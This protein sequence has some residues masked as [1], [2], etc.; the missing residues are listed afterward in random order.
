MVL[1]FDRPVRHRHRH[2]DL[3]GA[4]HATDRSRDGLS[5]TAINREKKGRPATLEAEVETLL[6]LIVA[7]SAQMVFHGMNEDDVRAILRYPH[8]MVGADGGVQDGQGLPHPR[9]YGTNARILGKYVREERL[10]T[11]EE[12]V[13]RM[14]SLAAQRF[15]LK[16]RGL[17]RAGYAADIVVFDPQRVIDTA[18]YS[19]P[20][21]FPVGIGHV[22]VNGRLVVDAG[23]HTGVRS[24]V[25]LQ[26]PGAT[27]GR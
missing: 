23:R 17:L 13:R 3:E 26:G 6:D 15:Q 14:T 24:G 7:G 11:L 4:R 8:N 2:T 20:H 1:V 19:N 25:A 21:Q 22:L 9:S 10:L 12:A 27:S 18:T 16:D 5:I